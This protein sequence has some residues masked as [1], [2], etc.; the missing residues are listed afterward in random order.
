MEIKI[1]PGNRVEKK[2]PWETES[3]INSAV[4]NPSLIDSMIRD[5]GLGDT[6]ITQDL[7]DTMFAV[8]K[9]FPENFA[10]LGEHRPA[11]KKARAGMAQAIS[12]WFKGIKII[13]EDST[14]IQEQVPLCL[15]NSPDSPGAKTVYGETVAKEGSLGLNIEV[16]GTGFGA[17]ATVSVQIESEFVS[18]SGEQKLVFAPLQM[19]V[20]KTALYKRGILQESFLK[21]ELAETEIHEANGLRSVK[22]AE[23]KKFTAG[24]RILDRFDLSGDKGADNAKYARSYAMQGTFEHK[25]GLDIFNLKASVVAKCTAKYTSNVTFEL[26][27]GRT[28]ELKAPSSLS[29]F[30][31][32]KHKN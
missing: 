8:A 29:G 28:Y 14:L 10:P 16:L 17:N 9:R 11:G 3:W 31:F 2:I 26:P 21:A 22:A 23:W 13:E 6:R 20:V 19:R 7:N 4:N 12:K 24:A 1:I 25:L 32:S 5:L 18:S 30:F 15:F 27:P